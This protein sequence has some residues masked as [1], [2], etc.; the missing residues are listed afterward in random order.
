[1]VDEIGSFGAFFHYSVAQLVY[2]VLVPVLLLIRAPHKTLL[3]IRAEAQVRV[4]S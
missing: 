4:H 1:M 3:L 2:M